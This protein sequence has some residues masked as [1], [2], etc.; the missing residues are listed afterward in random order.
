MPGIKPSPP[1]FSRILAR[2][3]GRVHQLGPA[4]HAHHGGLVAAPATRLPRAA[5]AGREEAWAQR[6]LST[7]RVHSALLPARVPVGGFVGGVGGLSSGWGRLLPEGLPALVGGRELPDGVVEVDHPAR[8][9]AEHLPRRPEVAAALP[10]GRVAARH[11]IPGP[12]ARVRGVHRH[13]GGL[14]LL[15][16]R[17]RRPRHPRSRSPGC[18]RLSPFAPPLCP[19]AWAPRIGRA[20]ALRRLRSTRATPEHTRARAR[21]RRGRIPGGGRVGGR[22]DAGPLRAPPGKA[23]AA[24]GVGPRD[25][26]Q[27]LPEHGLGKVAAEVGVE[28]GGGGGDLKAEAAEEEEAVLPVRGGHPQAH[29]LLLRTRRLL[30][31]VPNPFRADGA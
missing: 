6:R 27:A 2:F 9:P 5:P 18:G 22:V 8:G 13:K 30:A 25:G 1:S 10:Q 14:L 12:P 19:R 4:G 24:L 20:T 17:P 31:R 21:P 28:R 29:E 15:P 7:W 23:P 3:R 11:L 16:R 26:S